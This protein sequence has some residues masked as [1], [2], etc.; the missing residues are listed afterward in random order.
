VKIFSKLFY[1]LTPQE[2]R[3]AVLLFIITLIMALIDM[4]G[5]ASIMPFMA[6][7]SNPD[8]IYTNTI[9]NKIFQKSSLLGVQSDQEFIFFLGIL[10]FIFLIF[11]LS[12]KA[13]TTYFQLRFVQM[14]EYTIGK[15]LM[16]NYLYQPYSWFLNRNSSDI[17]KSILSEV[18]IIIGQGLSPMLNLITQCIIT[19]FIV[20]LLLIVDFKLTIIVTIILVIFYGLIFHLSRKFLNRIGYERVESNEFRFKAISE[21]FGAS[22]DVKLSGLE[23]IFIKKFSDPAKLFAKHQT[24]S[25]VLGKLPRFALEAIAFG[26]ML[27]VILYVISQTGN[28]INSIPIIT[29]YAFAGYRL[30]PSLQL[31]Y[32]SSTLLKYATPGINSLYNDFKSLNTH[33][34]NND[35]SILKF[36]KTISLNNVNY[37]YPNTSRTTLKNINL[38]IPAKSTVGLVGPTGC[39]KT[40]TVDIILGLLQ[41]QNGT[42]K[43]DDQIITKENSRSW[44]R[45]LGYVPQQIYLSDD[46]IASNIAFGINKENIIF[47]DLESAA[48]IANLHDFVINELPNK[49]ETKVGERGIRLSGGQRQRIGI[50]RALFHKP[51][52]LILDEATSALDNETEKAVMEAVNNLSKNIT[53][54][55]IAHRLSTVSKCDKI[56]HFDKGELIAEGPPEKLIKN[57]TNTKLTY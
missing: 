8:L 14:R 42:L 49:Y 29:L 3:N 17:G 20:S 34:Y 15:R 40:T 11:S 33:N 39:G 57:I 53:I 19:F 31:I 12:V 52:V 35:Q 21:A 24:S 45:S 25:Q 41:P 6:V 44:Q 16:E 26:G 50:A 30:M 4:F 22:K 7:V 51:K 37:S 54:I 23:K 2:K 43:I 9:L 10:V 48:K 32:A 38:I 56:F 55:M 27:V 28:F 1:F 47:E 18:G 13:L 5:V 46:T 36:D